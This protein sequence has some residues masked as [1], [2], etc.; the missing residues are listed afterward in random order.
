M[1]T[2]EV[3]PSPG[4]LDRDG[5]A[6]SRTPLVHQRALELGFELLCSFESHPP[7]FGFSEPFWLKGDDIHWDVSNVE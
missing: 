3:P 6:H 1:T 2:C 7:I 5:R 4:L